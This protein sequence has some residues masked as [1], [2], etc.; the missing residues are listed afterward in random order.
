MELENK[1]D[2]LI[3]EIGEFPLT[4]VADVDTIDAYRPCI[5]TI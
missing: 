1:T 2:M 3:A 5:R 4:E